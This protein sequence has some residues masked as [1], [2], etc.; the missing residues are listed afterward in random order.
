M[1]NNSIDNTKYGAAARQRHGNSTHHNFA[2]AEPVGVLGV[3]HHGDEELG[4]GL[5]ALLS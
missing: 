4:N 1:G 5:A 3:E 2:I